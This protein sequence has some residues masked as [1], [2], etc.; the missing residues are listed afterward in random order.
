MAQAIKDTNKN[1]T[2]EKCARDDKGNPT[3]NDESKLRAWKE[4]YQRLL[5][6]E[7]P[8]NTNSL[9][10]SAAVKGPAIFVTEDMVT[11]GIKTMKQGKAGGPS[12]VIVELIET[13]GRET[14]TAILDI[15]NRIIYE[16]NIPEE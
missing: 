13:C 7:F 12:E 10:N 14:V 6:V 2:R 16:E 11:D 8:W 5:N 3:L 1:V 4:G 15:V 9:N